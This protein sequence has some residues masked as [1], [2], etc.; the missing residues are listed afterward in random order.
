MVK[1][2]TRTRL[3]ELKRKLI[4]LKNL[5]ETV[6]KRRNFIARQLFSYLAIYSSLY[7]KILNLRDESIKEVLDYY[8]ENLTYEIALEKEELKKL[9]S[10]LE[11]ESE[12]LLNIQNN[13]VKQLKTMQK[14]SKKYHLIKDILIPKL[15]K[16]IRIIASYLDEKD[17][18]EYVTRAL[19]F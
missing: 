15:N 5:S 7:K 6:K 8:K 2:L 13:T 4:L 3:L 11:K 1:K 16:E 19:F 10:E 18:E 14:L 9:F 12:N 17:R